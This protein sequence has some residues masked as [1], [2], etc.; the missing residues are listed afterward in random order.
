VEFP[1]AAGNIIVPCIA[2]GKVYDQPGDCP[3]CGMHLVKSNGSNQ[4]LDEK[5][6]SEVCCGTITST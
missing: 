5:D 1:N 3:V 6:S 2:K 4:M